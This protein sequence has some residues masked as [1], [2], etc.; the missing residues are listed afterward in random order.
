LTADGRTIPL[1]Q[2]D[3]GSFIADEPGF[4]LFPIIFERDEAPKAAPTDKSKPPIIALAYGPD[5]Y[6]RAGFQGQKP[7]EPSEALSKYVG[8]FYSENPWNGT[9][10]I[11]QRQHQLWAGGTDPLVPIGNHLFRVGEEPSSPGVAEYAEF[12]DGKPQLLWVDGVMFQRVEEA[13]A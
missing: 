12:I 11:V 7:L 1:Q 10:R 13:S 2:S 6:A 9:I 8:Q 3:D 4:N 5:W